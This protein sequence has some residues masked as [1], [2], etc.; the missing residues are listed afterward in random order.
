MVFDKAFNTGENV[1]V[2]APTG[3]GKTNIALLTILQ[4][5]AKHIDKATKTLIPDKS[6][7]KIIYIS[8]NYYAI[9][10]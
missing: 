9:N 7:F 3:A 10:Y 8:R 5:V 6:E 4:E 2:C 1:L